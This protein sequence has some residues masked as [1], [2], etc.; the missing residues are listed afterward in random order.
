MV[1]MQTEIGQQPQTIHRLVSQESANIARVA[2]ALRERRPAAILIAARGTSDNAATYAKYLFGLVNHMVV[3]LAAPSLTTLYGA[4]LDL[5]RIAVIGVSQS[6]ESTDVV[7]VMQQARRSGSL[8]IGMTNNPSSPLAAAVE[9]P[10]NLHAGIE[11]ALPATKTYTAQ[12]AAFALLSAHLAGDAALLDGL[13]ALPDAIHATLALQPVMAEAAAGAANAEHC[14][15]LARGINY[16]TALEAALKLKETCYLG[17]EPYSTADFMHG[18][19]AI[20]SQGFPALLFAPEGKAQEAMKDMAAALTDRGATTIIMARDAALLRSAT[21]PVPL[22]CEVDER[23]SP[24][25]Y[26]VPAQLF[27]LHL[28]QVKGINPDAPRGL[29]K[30]TLTR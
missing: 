4:T 10:I 2:A 8:T 28:A 23:L 25:V 12:L 6:G 1:H 27:A 16:A 18:P 26:I 30:V 15:C 29:H 3:A 7:E 19:I 9:Y 24:I 17:A 14:V 21:L 22:P 11:R 5:S 20:V 13:A